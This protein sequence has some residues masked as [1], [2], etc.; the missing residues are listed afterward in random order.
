M[1]LLNQLFKFLE[2]LHSETSTH[3]LS[4]GFVLGLFVGFT[5]MFTLFQALYLTLMLF[6]RINIGAVFLSAAL[7]ELMSFFLD[8]VFDS[9]GLHLLRSEWL[10]PLWTS[11]YAFPVIAYT[12][13][14]NTVVMG[15]VALAGLLGLPLFF[16][17]NWLICRY[18]VTVVSR[19]K[20]TWVF[21][22]WKSSK[23]YPLYAKYTEFKTS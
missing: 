6:L 10:Q 13:F 7:F 16:A 22:A 23:L 2:L 17:S 5:P 1:F 11:L 18:R 21:R 8:P 3:Q 4:S 15:S 19:I 9:V 20:T 14:Y 12:F